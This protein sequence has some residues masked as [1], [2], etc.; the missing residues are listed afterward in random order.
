[1]L[2]KWIFAA[3]ILAL[4]THALAQVERGAPLSGLRSGEPLSGLRGNAQGAPVG[5]GDLPVPPNGA[6]GVPLN[7]VP[8]LFRS[9]EHPLFRQM[10]DDAPT[11]RP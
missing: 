10:D 6:P 11:L 2:R 9:M 5:G 8:P 3:A 7:V 4:P 1:M